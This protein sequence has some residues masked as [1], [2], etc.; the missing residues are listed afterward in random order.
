M[1]LALISPCKVGTLQSS[2]RGLNVLGHVLF[3]AESTLE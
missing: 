2:L 3:F 1:V